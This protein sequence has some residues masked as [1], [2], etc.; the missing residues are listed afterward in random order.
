MKIVFRV[1]ASTLIGTGHVVRCLTLATALRD[2]GVDCAFICRLHP[3]NMANTIRSQGFVVHELPTHVSGVTSYTGDHALWLGTSTEQ[4]AKETAAILRNAPPDWLLVDH[5][6]LDKTWERIMHP[7]CGRLMVLDDLADRPHDCDLLLDQNWFGDAMKHRYEGLLPAR[8]VKLLG[9]GFALL[10]PEYKLLRALMP[11][12]DGVVR[13]VL[14]FF[15]GSD[16]TNQTRKALDALIVPDL[17]FLA[18]DV[19]VGVNHPDPES[20]LALAQ[21]RAGT[22]AHQN[23]PSLAGLMARADLM[24]G[25]GGT[26]TWE[27]MCLGL[28]TIVLSMAPNQ[29][30]INATLM[31]AGHIDYLGEMADVSAENISN[32]VRRSLANPVGLRNQ[33]FRMQELVLPDGPERVFD[34][35]SSN[36]PVTGTD[37]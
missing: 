21:A 8:T 13:R 15:G 33:S 2:R 30:P 17:A 22:L 35:L 16:P 25:G 6:A 5:Y 31:S 1:D 32:A 26:T 19:V 12:R 3:G 29:N 37:G 7:F 11:P 28:P 9:P 34:Y 18:V 24:I 20:I 4:D 10:K 14:V 23:L 36:T 27:R